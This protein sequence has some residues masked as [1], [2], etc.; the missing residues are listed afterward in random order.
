MSYADEIARQIFDGDGMIYRGESYEIASRAD[1]EIRQLR[2][3][4][5]AERNKSEVFRQAACIA[6]ESK[7]AEV[8]P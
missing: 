4:L 1:A 3:E 2:E 6:A 7:L 5:E 8:K